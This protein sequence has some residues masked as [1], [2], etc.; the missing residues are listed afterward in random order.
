MKIGAIFPNLFKSGRSRNSKKKKI[1]I[2]KIPEIT[3]LIQK[4]KKQIISFF[5]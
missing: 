4:T 5:L 3:Y 1:F 2:F